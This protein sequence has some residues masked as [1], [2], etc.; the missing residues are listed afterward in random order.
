VALPDAEMGMAI[1][2]I[3][4]GERQDSFEGTVSAVH[5]RN[6]VGID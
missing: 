5:K 4:N 3:E 2:L 6:N 1:D